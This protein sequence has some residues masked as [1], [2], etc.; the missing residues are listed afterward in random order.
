MGTLESKSF[1]SS[2]LKETLHANQK[3]VIGNTLPLSAASLPPPYSMCD[4][5]K[6]TQ[7]E[8]EPFPSEPHLTLRPLGKMLRIPCV[9][10]FLCS[11]PQRKLK[12]FLFQWPRFQGAALCGGAT[13]LAAYTKYMCVWFIHYI[14]YELMSC[15]LLGIGLL[16][17]YVKRSIDSEVFWK[18]YCILGSLL[19]QYHL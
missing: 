6:D 3:A 1:N 14:H 12:L 4:H 16:C 10:M 18:T 5:I 15:A 2:E 17:C 11:M 8:R 7:R 19:V 13:D 9:C